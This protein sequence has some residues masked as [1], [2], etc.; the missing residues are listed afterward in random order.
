MLKKVLLERFN[1]NFINSFF[2]YLVM[3]EFVNIEKKWQKKWEDK[4]IFK[5]KEDTKK[6]KYF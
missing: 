3:V 6:P 1:I 2:F 5:V 4:N